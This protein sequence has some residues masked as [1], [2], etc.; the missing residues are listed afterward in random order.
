MFSSILNLVK[1]IIGSGILSIP[2]ALSMQ[3]LIPGLIILTIVTIMCI[4][5]MYLLCYV[6]RYVP[7]G[8]ATFFN[9]CKV[10][11]P[12]L[13]VV[14]DLSIAIQCFGCMISYIILIGEIMP[15][16]VRN[17]PNIAPE[18][19]R[20]FWITLSMFVCVPLSFLKN[21]K[22]LRFSAFLGLVAILYMI[23]FII[24]M[25]FTNSVPEEMTGPISLFPEHPMNIFFSF[26]IMLF[27][28]AGHQNLFS[29]VNESRDKS[30]RGMVIVVVT[31]LIVAYLLNVLLGLFG[32]MTF[33]LKILG[34]IMLMYEPSPSAIVGRTAIVVMVMCSFPFL[35]HPCRISVNNTSIHLSNKIKNK[36]AKKNVSSS[37]TSSSPENPTKELKVDESLKKSDDLENA[38]NSISNTVVSNDEVLVNQGEQSEQSEQ[39]DANIIII[40]NKSFIAIT[41]SLLVCSYLIAFLTNSFDTV[42]AVVGSTGCTIL[43]FILPGLFGFKLIGSEKE[44]KSSYE[45][46]LN[47]ISLASVF[48]GFFVMV[49]CLYSTFSRT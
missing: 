2:F 32:Y 5:T 41:I 11:Y 25:Y 21:L 6:T 42:L 3:G 45:K 31:A 23:V 17:I 37:E 12:S 46:F 48:F 14:F 39:V 1:T 47:Y 43:T 35:V 36:K 33:G 20:F 16:I 44:K 13:S 22:S 15:M 49:I 40:T 29:I 19:H 28:L 10:S 24:V 30:M 9:V 8:H 18:Y 7:S 34:N 38:S 27:A 4:F 26:S